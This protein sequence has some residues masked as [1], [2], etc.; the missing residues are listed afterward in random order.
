MSAVGISFLLM[1]FLTS[2]SFAAPVPAV[3]DTTGA[4]TARYLVRIERAEVVPLNVAETLDVTIQTFG[5]PYAA[6]ALKIGTDSKYIDIVDIQRG[7]IIDTCDWEYFNVARLKTDNKSGYPM[8]LWSVVALAKFSPDTTK[9]GCLGLNREAS[10]MRLIVTSAPNV[11]IRDS[12]AS[13]CFFWEDCRDNTISDA[14]GAHLV[15]SR[16]IIDYFDNRIPDS[17]TAFPTRDGA[18]E[19]CINRRLPHHP[20]RGIEFHNGGLKFT[21]PPHKSS[22]ESKPTKTD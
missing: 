11:E 7:E 13:I 5:W 8:S 19:A 16:Q 3:M 4:D 10:F 9:P 18:L 17:V 1:V 21:L 20:Q 6:C 14:S 12:T 22:G 2:L 15:I